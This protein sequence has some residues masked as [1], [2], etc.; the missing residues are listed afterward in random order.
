MPHTDPSE[1]D[2]I[3]EGH[4]SVENAV[5]HLVNGCTGKPGWGPGRLCRAW[6]RI[7][8]A[9]VVEPDEDSDDAIAEDI[10]GQ[11][12]VPDFAHAGMP[13]GHHGVEA[14][15]FAEPTDDDWARGYLGFGQ[16]ESE[17]MRSFVAA[18]KEAQ[19]V[20]PC[21]FDLSG[22]DSNNL[23]GAQLSFYRLLQAAMAARRPVRAVVRGGGGTGKSYAINCFRR[24]LSEHDVFREDSIVV[25][26]PTGTAAYNV[27]GRTLHSALKLPVPLNQSTFQRLASGPSLTDMQQAFR[28]VKVVVI[29]EMSMVGRRMLRALDDRL[30]QAKAK[31]DVPFGGVSIFLCGDFGQLPPVA[32]VTMYDDG[33][34]GGD[35]S[36]LGRLTWR[37]CT[38]SLELTQNHRQSGD[39]TGFREALWRLRCGGT[40]SQD[41]NLFT[42]RGEHR[43]GSTG[44]EDAIYLVATHALEQEFNDEKLR[45]LQKPVYRIDTSHTGGKAARSADDQDAGGLSKTMLLAEGARVMLRTNLWTGAG[46]TNGA[47]GEFVQLIARQANQLPLAALVRFPSYTGPAFFQTTRSLCQC[48]CTHRISVGMV[49]KPKRSRKH[50]Y[51]WRLHGPSPSTSRRAPPTTMPLSTWVKKKS[52]LV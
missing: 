46:L 23:H 15:R 25:L 24:W 39:T 2:G 36:K 29:D 52:P 40:T 49:R 41:Y 8:K 19:G 1:L 26:A 13:A 48:R 17:R 30:R 50:S 33:D 6:A 12:G 21:E 28:S 43:V 18:Q 5:Q 20:D 34:K 9:D 7:Q 45:S 44:F 37:A 27:A 31:P 22:Y 14:G 35:L 11:R 51:R 38:H 32:D 10:A 16:A 3:V 47:I 4:G 42:T